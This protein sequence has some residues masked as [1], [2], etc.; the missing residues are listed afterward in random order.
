MA[1]R[2]SSL[3]DIQ[4]PY[5]APS[6]KQA[7]TQTDLPGTCYLMDWN[8]LF[9]E[10]DTTFR[11]QYTYTFAAGEAREAST[12]FSI[13]NVGTW[14]ISDRRT[15]SYDQWGNAQGILSESWNGSGWDPGARLT[16][17]YSSDGILLLHVYESYNGTS[18]DTAAYNR[19]LVTRNSLNQPLEVTSQERDPWQGLWQNSLK[20]IYTYG[21][22]NELATYEKQ[23]WQGSWVNQFLNRGYTWHDFQ[24]DQASEYYQDVWDVVG[25]SYIN[26]G[27]YNFQYTDNYGSYIRNFQGYDAVSATYDSL[28]KDMFQYDAQ[29]SLILEE[30]FAW[31]DTT[32]SFIYQYGIQLV[33]T[34]NAYGSLVEST[35]NRRYF[36]P[37]PWGPDKRFSCVDFQVGQQPAIEEGLIVQWGPHPVGQQ[38]TLLLDHPRPGTFT[39]Q[40]L[41]MQGKQ[42]RQYQSRHTGGMQNHDFDLQLPSGLYLY[43][44]SMGGN[45]QSGRLLIN[46]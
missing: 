11:Y 23:I 35:T 14:V 31:D 6:S 40:I 17:N 18:Y 27:Q 46:P 16:S 10:W 9:S 38:G 33:P 42:L 2:S 39:L 41:D 20:E 37:G 45:S 1:Q 3:E 12:I 25:S 7:G 22:S 5:P 34:Y 44:I 15:Y 21:P 28:Q 24:A 19:K 8:T 32:S 43:Q 4:T 36:D 26:N 29:G 13:Y 30:S